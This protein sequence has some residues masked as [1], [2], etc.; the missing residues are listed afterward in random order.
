MHRCRDVGSAPKG[1]CALQLRKL[2]LRAAESKQPRAS[3]LACGSL[4]RAKQGCRLQMLPPV[5]SVW[6][7]LSMLRSLCNGFW[8]LHAG[9]HG[10]DGAWCVRVGL[11]CLRWGGQHPYYAM[12]NAREPAAAQGVATFL[13]HELWHSVP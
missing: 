9:M 6:P 4:S 7:A 11:M 3:Q 10:H 13:S 12:Q 2:A 1:R 5:L 8:V